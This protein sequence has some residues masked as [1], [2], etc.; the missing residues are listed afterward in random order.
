MSHIDI[1]DDY[2]G[3]DNIA[4]Q[5]GMEKTIKSMKYDQVLEFVSKLHLSLPRTQRGSSPFRILGG[6]E[7]SG[8]GL[9][10]TSHTCRSKSIVNAAAFASFFCDELILYDPTTYMVDFTQSGFKNMRGSPK[11]L[12]FYLRELAMLSP[13]PFHHPV[14]NIQHL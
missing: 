7:M 6:S 10:C 5:D 2:V 4:D 1:I 8:F 3:L 13:F 14:I 9:A 12:A 11:D